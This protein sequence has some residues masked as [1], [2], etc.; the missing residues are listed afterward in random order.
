MKPRH[1]AA[2]ALVGWYLMSAGSDLKSSPALS[3]WTIMGSF[4]TATEWEVRQHT[5]TATAI[6]DLKARHRDKLP[7][8]QLNSH[9]DGW[10][11]ALLNEVCIATDDPRLKER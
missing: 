11:I 8:S 3:S 1:A 4:D 10:D 9:D 6:K 7:A 2:L 5:D